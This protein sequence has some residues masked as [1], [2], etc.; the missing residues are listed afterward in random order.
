MQNLENTF[1]NPALMANEGYQAPQ[2][3][4]ILG[5]GESGMA[6]AKWC[7][8][9]GA[10]VRLADT[11]E[12]Q[13]LSECQKA[14]LSELEYAGLKDMHFGPLNET[15]LEGIEVIGISPGLSPIQEPAQS[16][17][18]KAKVAQVDIWS[19]IEFFARAIAAME[20][21]AQSESQ[22]YKPSI[23]AIT[24]TN[25]KTTTTAL[26]GQLCERAGKKVAIA[27]NISPAALDK[28]ISC[29]EQADQLTDMPDIWVL[30]L[31]SFQ[32]VYTYSLNATAATVL[33]ITQDHLDW[34]GDMQSYAQAKANIFGVDTVCI[35][36]RDDASYATVF[37]HY[38]R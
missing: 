21:M 8:R 6:M 9:N 28:L 38:D 23:L 33:N 25:G 32:L 10:A 26:T 12:T 20:R 11:R 35:L 13:Q 36:N 29:L 5:L 1:A 31:S 3:F 14:W 2:N 7:L 16:F 15:L 19:E 34:H 37:I 17:L 22:I 27:G 4:L 30:E 18:D 24:G